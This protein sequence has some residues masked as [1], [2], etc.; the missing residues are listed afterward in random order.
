MITLFGQLAMEVWKICRDKQI[1]GAWQILSTDATFS[2]LGFCVSRGIRYSSRDLWS[3]HDLHDTQQYNKYDVSMYI[4]I[5]TLY[6]FCID[7][8]IFSLHQ[9]RG[10]IIVYMCRTYKSVQYPELTIFS[11]DSIKKA[12]QATRIQQD[13]NATAMLQSSNSQGGVC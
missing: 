1:S 5:C 2:G 7:T 11:V 6:I 10:R 13:G 3:S 12:K 8:Y 9:N 4:Q